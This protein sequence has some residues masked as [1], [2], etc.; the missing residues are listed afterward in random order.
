MTKRTEVDKLEKIIG[1][2]SVRSASCP[3]SGKVIK[4]GELQDLVPFQCVS[5]DV[6]VINVDAAMEVKVE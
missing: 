4:L 6:K 3:A 1:V 5:C 2:D